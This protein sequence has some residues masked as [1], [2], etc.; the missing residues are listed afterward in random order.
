MT[1]IEKLQAV[2][3]SESPSSFA[4]ENVGALSIRLAE[5]I[6]DSAVTL[7]DLVFPSYALQGR[8]LANV[9]IPMESKILSDT[10]SKVLVMHDVRI[11]DRQ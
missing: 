3:A 10:S 8:H 9:T 4:R 11:G 5:R 2:A 7:E 1:A 6:S